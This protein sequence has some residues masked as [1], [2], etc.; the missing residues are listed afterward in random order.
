[1]SH[2]TD[3]GTELSGDLLDHFKA[4][5][6]DIRA[7]EER[8]QST[9]LLVLVLGVAVN[10]GSLH[11]KKRH[12]IKDELNGLPGVAAW[13]PE[14]Q[15]MQWLAVNQLGAP[16]W[17]QDPRVHQL[18]QFKLAD[19]I[20]ALEPGDAVGQEVAIL[21][22]APDLTKKLIDLLPEKY[23][24]SEVETFS[25]LLRKRA[26]A[27]VEYY[28]PEQ[29]KSCTVATVAVPKMVKTQQIEKWLLVGG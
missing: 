9:P 4:H 10:A 24:K 8:I 25:G 7:V 5:E 16:K 27:K 28:T 12:Q 20:V 17:D 23:R 11:S 3:L 21:T 19:S 15:E 22:G 6:D 13:F 18:V 14:D 26:G 29:L 1:M 2:G